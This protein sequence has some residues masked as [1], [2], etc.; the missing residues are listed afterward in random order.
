[1][2]VTE[3]AFVHLSS[4][5]S[6][7]THRALEEAQRTQDKWVREKDPGLPATRIARG[8]GMLQRTDDPSAILVT[9]RWG[10]PAA[11]WEWIGTEENKQAMGRLMPLMVTGGEKKP[12]LFHVDSVLFPPPGDGVSSALER[13]VLGLY[14]WRVS[15]SAKDEFESKLRETMARIN[16]GGKTLFRW[17]WR[18]EKGDDDEVQELLMVRGW[19]SEE[20]RASGEHGALDEL[21]TRALDVNVYSYKRI[22]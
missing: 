16:I 11:H 5:L 4:P 7:D 8:T 20:Q 6:A 17:G 10:S 2:T 3:F 15:S 13:P 14:H 9:A 18:I 22:V 12:L 1:M 19:D 21:S